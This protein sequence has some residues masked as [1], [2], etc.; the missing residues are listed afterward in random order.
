MCVN[1]FAVRAIRSRGV[2]Q[3]GGRIT[4]PFELRLE[5]TERGLLRAEE[6]VRR[7]TAIGGAESRHRGLEFGPAAQCVGPVMFVANG[8]GCEPG[9][10]CVSVFSQVID[11]PVAL[12]AALE[13]AS[14]SRVQT[15][16]AERAADIKVETGPDGKRAH[17]ADLDRAR[18]TTLDK[19][20]V[21]AAF[22]GNFGYV[23]ECH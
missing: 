18:G 11:M 7:A 16:R 17:S 1:F 21:R 22:V 20:N 8:I 13:V 2:E 19:K 15:T 12:V 9:A 10:D 23:D 5:C 14:Q 6:Q 4:A 3:A